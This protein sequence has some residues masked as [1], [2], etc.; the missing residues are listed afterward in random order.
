MALAP[1]L[2]DPVAF[3]FI[4]LGSGVAVL[5]PLSVILSE[6]NPA[7]KRAGSWRSGLALVVYAMAFSLAYVSLE[8]GMG[9]LLLFGSVQLTMIGVGLWQ[10]ERPSAGEWI[11]LGVAMAGLVYLVMP[12]ISA[13]DPLGAALMFASGVAWGIY[14]LRGRGRAAPIAATAG[15]FTRALPFAALALAFDSSS[16][17]VT[18]RG[19]AL[20]VASGAITSGVG[21]ILWYRALRD[22]SATRAA[23]VQLAVPVIAAAGG[24]IVLAEEPT[25]RLGI[26]SL[27]ILGGVAAAIL[28]RGRQ[29]AA[30]VKRRRSSDY[31]GR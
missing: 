5:V 20:A 9:A 30:L 26:A 31:R 24:I 10:G 11:G 18:P 28:A 17:H 13:P 22:L 21:Y 1:S 14:S 8:T 29:T 25:L 7:G 16:L 27:M 4:R 19:I 2:V 23:I 3:T 12:G 6:P 15:N